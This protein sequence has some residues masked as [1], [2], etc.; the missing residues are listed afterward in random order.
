MTFAEMDAGSE[1]S[2][3]EVRN[4]SAVIAS[5]LSLC[6]SHLEWDDFLESHFAVHS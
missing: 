2:P 1:N 4:P 6:Q 3:D 5:T